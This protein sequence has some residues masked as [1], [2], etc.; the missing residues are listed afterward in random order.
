MPEGKRRLTLGLL[1]DWV[2]TPY[3]QGLLKG[4]SDYALEQDLNLLFYVTGRYQSQWESEKCRNVFFDFITG[5]NVDGLLVTGSSIGNLCGY[6]AVRNLLENYIHIPL[7][8]IGDHF[9]GIP[10]VSVDN[11][12]GMKLVL[13]HLIHV[14]GYKRFGFI[15]GSPDNQEAEARFTIFRDTLRDNGLELLRDFIYKGNFRQ[16]DGY[17]FARQLFGKGTPPLD[18]VISSNDTMALGFLQAMKEMEISIPEQIALTG[19]DDSEISSYAGLTTVKQSFEELGRIAASLLTDRIRGNPIPETT[20]LK[21]KLAIR[22]SCGCR[23]FPTWETQPLIRPEEPVNPIQAAMPDRHVIDGILRYFPLGDKDKETLAQWGEELLEEYRRELVQSSKEPLFLKKWRRIVNWATKR[24]KIL[25]GLDRF[26]GEFLSKLAVEEHLPA[27]WIRYW[28]DVL[29]LCLQALDQ[30]RQFATTY[31]KI[32]FDYQLEAID[33]SGER[34]LGTMERKEQLDVVC[35][36]FPRLGIKR[37]YISLYEDPANPLSLSRLILAYDETSRMPL[38]SRGVQ[39]PTTMMLPPGILSP[40]KRYE[41]LV[42]A[43]F[44]GFDQLGF[45]LFDMESREWRTMEILRHKLATA[46]RASHMFEEI[47]GYT[48]KLEEQVDQRTREL[49]ETNHKLRQEIVERKRIEQELIRREEHFRELALLL[50]TMI[51]ELDLRLRITFINQ[52]GLEVFGRQENDL[53]GVDTFLDLVY[54][55]D[56]ENAEEAL[57]KI[58]RLKKPVYGEFRLLDGEGHPASL[59]IN[60]SPII[61]DDLVKGVRLS[62]MRI[63]PLLSSVIMPEDLFFEHYKFSP[64]VKEVLLLMLQGYKTKDIAV[65]LFIAENTVK[66][67]IRAIY[68]EVGVQNRSEFFKIL[69]EYQVNQFGYQSYIHSLLSKLIRE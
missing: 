50:P 16:E 17:R 29:P 51:V 61:R 26:A 36:E 34:L 33:D 28:N 25:D 10:S 15:H 55:E 35:R 64:R 66:A 41:F 62:A 56:Q 54:G 8:T 44:Q 39:F 6:Q 48:E 47:R 3:H 7:V 23:D 42:E 4:I 1:I 52:A 68:T 59:L 12:A 11:N 32:L 14:H 31:G 18:A 46:F 67:H 45:V 22:Q 20:V 60:A 63:K 58:I 69:E 2:G 65:K 13:D 49:N 24:E 40:G 53:M 37:C 19:Y 27:S 9:P 38:D 43:L 30:A 21:P 5:Y 57:T